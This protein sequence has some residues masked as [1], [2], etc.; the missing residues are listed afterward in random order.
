MVESARK[1]YDF[2][3]KKEPEKNSSKFRRRKE[4]KR[5]RNKEQA[6]LKG[7][8]WAKRYLKRSVRKK[9]KS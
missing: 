5:K 4:P 7:E 2:E 8:R 1:V 9:N 3:L 6:R